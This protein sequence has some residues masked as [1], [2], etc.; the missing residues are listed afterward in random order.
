MD[1]C[2]V[3]GQ[4]Y[5]YTITKRHIL[6]FS[7][8]GPQTGN[9]VTINGAGFRVLCT[10]PVSMAAATSRGRAFHKT[11]ANRRNGRKRS[12]AHSCTNKDCDASVVD[13]IRRRWAP[14]VHASLGVGP[15]IALVVHVDQDVIVDGS[16][17]SRSFSSVTL[18][19][20]VC[21]SAF[22]SLDVVTSPAKGVL[23]I[24]SGGGTRP[25]VGIPSA[26]DAKS[27]QDLMLA[28]RPIAP[29]D[30][31]DSRRGSTR[32]TGPQKR[33]RTLEGPTDALTVMFA[34]PK[35]PLNE[36]NRIGNHNV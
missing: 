34:R 5:L 25:V 23:G 8:V 15:R 9:T 10:H 17:V 6:V 35:R 4:Q 22:P 2:R 32:T 1:L 21:R 12:Q 14:E 20:G 30:D 24:V 28:L 26:A 19:I 18:R 36:T 29:P 16:R 13:V 27:R 3:R 31:D 7:P 11:P 33:R